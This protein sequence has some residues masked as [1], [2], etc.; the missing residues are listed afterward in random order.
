MIDGAMD[1]V[2]IM[3]D[4]SPALIGIIQVPKLTTYNEINKF[5]S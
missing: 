2:V 4:T 1:A 3:V 5:M